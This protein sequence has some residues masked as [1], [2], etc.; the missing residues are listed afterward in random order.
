YV[1]IFTFLALISN[2]Q[3]ITR[4]DN[5]KDIAKKENSRYRENKIQNSEWSEKSKSPL[6]FERNGRIYELKYINSNGEPQYLITNNATAAATVSTQTLYPLGGLGLNLTGNGIII[7]EWD[8]GSALVSHQE[9]GGRVVAADGASSDDHATHVAGTIMA[10]GIQ[11]QAKGMAYEALLRSFDWNNDISEMATE[12]SNGA[13]ISNHSYGLVRGWSDGIW[14]GDPEISTEEDYLFGFYDYWTSQFD[15]V[16]YNAPYYLICKAAGNDRADS[17]DG[18]PSDGP[19]DCIEQYAVAKN[20]LTVGAVNDIPLGYSQP[21][22]VVMTTFSSWGP[23]DDG[24]IKPDIVANGYGLYSAS[25][26]GNTKY[27]TKWGTSMATPSVTGSLALLQQHY[28]NL[29]GNYMRASTLKALAIHTAD[30]AGDNLG[31]DY[32]FG[33]GLLNTASAVQMISEDLSTDVISEH[34]LANGG[35]FTREVTAKGSEPLKATIVW[36]DLP[37]IPV[38]ASLD[39][40][41]PMLVNDLDLKIT[42][43]LSTYY[44]WKLDRLNPE[45]AATNNS[46]N[47]VDNVEVVF[48]ENPLAGGVYTIRVDHDGALANGSQSFSLIV[49][50]IQSNAAPIANF[51]VNNTNAT[52]ADILTFTDLSINDPAS[53]NW[54]IIPST[55]TYKNSTSATS[56]N[57][58][59]SFYEAGNYTIGLTATNAIGSDTEIKTNFI[60][61]TA[62]SGFSLPYYEGFESGI[63][64][65]SCWT[66]VDSDGDGNNWMGVSTPNAQEGSNAAYSES[67]RNDLGSLTPDNWLITPGLKSN[68][69]S[70]SIKFWVKPIDPICLDDKFSVLISTASNEVSDFTE[71]YSQ[72]TMAVG[73]NEIS[74]TSGDLVGKDFY[75]AFR[76]WDCSDIYQILL[77]NISIE[78]VGIPSNTSIVNRTIVNGETTCFNAIDTITVAGNGTFVDFESG[79]DVLLIA[80]KSIRFLPGFH[81]FEGSYMNA[82]ITTNNTFCDDFLPSNLNNYEP[83]AYKSG[84]LQETQSLK[85]VLS[86]KLDVNI[87]PNPNNGRFIVELNQFEGV[88]SI[89]VLDL[90]GITVLSE[91]IHVSEQFNVELP[92]VRQGVYLVQIN[93]GQE[94]ITRKII[95]KH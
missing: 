65:P 85:K 46:K 26:S 64:P 74:I 52:V 32:K 24:R 41:D 45:N 93:N 18:Y 9:F 54:S 31:P 39:P 38:E 29:K 2:S 66:T 61:V 67:Y 48:L 88:V 16:A 75:I 28:Y 55:F 13:L 81:A 27:A 56:Q 19:Y 57:P 89:K 92:N 95:I 87:Y 10:A 70:I 80:G 90:W 72:N 77:D 91:N 23:A 51:T 8:A 50:G 47:N 83:I 21:S 6:R 84:K 78:E 15:N 53:W 82:S 17:G 25:N 49:S 86:R 63:F 58:Q 7:R 14:H 34:T 71:I 1:L 4:I 42:A 37:G 69:E 79:S 76:H 11:A 62:C 73:W 20:I 33:W 44:P 94:T 12:A 5:L 3:S 59:V 60:N 43:N 35:N 40:L 22:D 30:E 36:T 68:A